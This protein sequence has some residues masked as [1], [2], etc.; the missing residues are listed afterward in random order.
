MVLL[1]FLTVQNKP[2]PNFKFHTHPSYCKLTPPTCMESSYFTSS[3]ILS[4]T[5][6]RP[7]PFI[8]AC[9][10]T[11]LYI[12]LSCLVCSLSHIHD[13]TLLTLLLLSSPLLHPAPHRSFLGFKKS[14]EEGEKKER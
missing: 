13:F 4:D 5:F 2:L 6:L 3:F 11:P 9:L 1:V 12:Y 7:S 10:V 8:H 14:D